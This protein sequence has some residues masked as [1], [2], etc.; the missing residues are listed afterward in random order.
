MEAGGQPFL[1]ASRGCLICEVSTSGQPPGTRPGGPLLPC[2]PAQELSKVA[3]LGASA[4]SLVHGQ[5]KPGGSPPSSTSHQCGLHLLVGKN[6]A[7]GVLSAQG[8][9]CLCRSQR[10]TGEAAWAQFRP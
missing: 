9:D 8:S 7:A 10:G 4:F 6:R 5:S 2:L 3:V 1:G